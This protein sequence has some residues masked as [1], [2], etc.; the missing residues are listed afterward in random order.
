MLLRANGDH[1][2][3]TQRDEYAPVLFDR[4]EARTLHAA[5]GEA[6]GVEDENK[7]LREAIDS[8]L[9]YLK[10]Q[11]DCASLRDELNQALERNNPSR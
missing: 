8:A 6:L 7:K 11:W 5:L 1:F 4:D 3:I 10:T 9:D 2:S